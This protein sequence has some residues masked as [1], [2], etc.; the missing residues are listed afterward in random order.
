[1]WARHLL[2]LLKGAAVSGGFTFVKDVSRDF[3]RT[4]ALSEAA[5]QV[6]LGGV[7]ESRKAEICFNSLFQVQQRFWPL[8]F[9][10]SLRNEEPEHSLL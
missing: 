8:N 4:G 6:G 9:F 3:S 5:W 10:R 1:M 7:L 2:P